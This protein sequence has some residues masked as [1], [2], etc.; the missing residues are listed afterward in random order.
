MK[1]SGVDANLLTALDALLSEKSV[2][3]A[4]RRLGIGQPAL[5]HSLARLREH[6]QDELL[7]LRGRD[8]V[9]TRTAE[10][11]AV[12]SADAVRALAAVFDQQPRFD[13]ASASSRFVIACSE[14]LAIRLM[15]DLAQALH[16]EAEHVE[17]E[18]RPP[19]AGSHE[20]WL[21]GGVDLAIGNFE[22]V[23]AHLNQ[24]T[25][26]K[27]HPACVVSVDNPRV[28]KRLTLS[29]F[30]DLPHLDIAPDFDATALH[31][32][33]ALSAL[34]KRRRVTLRIPYYLLSPG[35]LERTDHVATLAATSAAFLAQTAAL[36]VLP[37][38][39]PLP[40][41]EVSLIWH[42]SRNPDPGHTWLRA[43][44]AAICQARPAPVRPVPRRRG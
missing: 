28:Q 3:R 32:D 36:R 15:P 6:F 30:A 27:E 8:Y 38:P 5:S 18:V 35:I 17:L 21:D 20:S 12:S 19:V 29:A 9:L 7:V 22:N 16:R 4:A 1:I 44:I 25:L 31:L 14:L 40:S 24:R 26:Y 42:T 2:T 11:L 43:R 34:G 13:A 10:R 33:R 37:P 39:I 23:P 41:Y